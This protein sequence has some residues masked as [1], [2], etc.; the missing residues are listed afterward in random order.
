MQEEKKNSVP[1]SAFSCEESVAFQ[2]A[3][4]QYKRDSRRPNPTCA[5]VLA[6]F[7][8]MGYR[9]VATETPLPTYPRPG[10]SPPS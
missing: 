3:M 7:L 9:K 10:R 8:S 6:V 5:E 4:E 2:Q 1:V